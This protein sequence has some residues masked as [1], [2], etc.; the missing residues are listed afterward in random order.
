M[1]VYRRI[2]WFYFS[3]TWVIQPAFLQ[4]LKTQIKCRIILEN[5]KM[6]TFDLSKHFWKPALVLVNAIV[7]LQSGLDLYEGLNKSLHFY[8]K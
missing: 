4:W 1:A 5:I 8:A 6:F 7:V 3:I 2:V